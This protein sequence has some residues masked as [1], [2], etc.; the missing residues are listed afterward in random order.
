ML[1][2]IFLK[3]LETLTIDKWLEYIVLSNNMDVIKIILTDEVNYKDRNSDQ[4]KAL[5][6]LLLNSSRWTNDDRVKLIDYYTSIKGKGIDDHNLLILKHLK[7]EILS[8]KKYLQLA[9]INTPILPTGETLLHEAV[10]KRNEEFVKFL[11]DQGAKIDEAVKKMMEA[12]IEKEKR[13]AARKGN[14]KEF[15]SLNTIEKVIKGEVK[16]ELSPEAKSRILAAQVLLEGKDKSGS[17][18]EPQ[19]EQEREKLG[20]TVLGDKDSA[21]QEDLPLVQA[22]KI[23][24]KTGW[25][26]QWQDYVA[27]PAQEAYTATTRAANSWYSWLKNKVQGGVTAVQQGA[28]SW[29]NYLLGGS[30]RPAGASKP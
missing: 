30:P 13:L 11:I 12:S 1:L 17:E 5:Y 8:D 3:T 24:Q 21:A 14:I 19:I 22:R 7:E 18:F 29:Y 16:I 23:V 26:K 15:I 9:G 10:K 20:K 6:L 27:T 25:A 2:E 4:L 28:T